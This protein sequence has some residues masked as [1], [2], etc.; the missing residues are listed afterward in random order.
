MIII[1]VNT[2][3]KPRKRIKAVVAAKESTDNNSFEKEM[4]IRK[5]RIDTIFKV[6]YVVAVF[7]AAIFLSLS[8]I[9]TQG[10]T[11]VYILEASIAGLLL[12]LLL[13]LLVY[14][15]NDLKCIKPRRGEVL[16]QQ[17]KKTED[18]YEFVFTYFVCGGLSSMVLFS[19]GVALK[20]SLTKGFFAL[21]F[22]LCG[23]TASFLWGCFN[24]KGSKMVSVICCILWTIVA[25]SFF[26]ILAAPQ[27]SAGA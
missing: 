18:S 7:F 3:K 12:C 15:F 8:S 13:Y 10:L 20:D 4:E 6:I 11:D 23:A 5:N 9:Y 1:N 14:V 26:A 27:G 24:K 16:G 2:R 19:L 21:V 25:F 17:Y 22:M